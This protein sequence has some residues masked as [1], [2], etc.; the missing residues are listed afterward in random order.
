MLTRL[1]FTSGHPPPPPTPSIVG[2][3]SQ[4]TEL[5]GWAVALCRRMSMIGKRYAFLTIYISAHLLA[6]T[7][8]AVYCLSNTAADGK[9]LA[10]QVFHAVSRA[11]GAVLYLD[12]AFVLFPTCH[13]LMCLLRQTFLARLL[14]LDSRFHMHELIAWSMV[15]FTWVHVSAQW[16]LLAWQ[17]ASREAGFKGFL[18]DSFA[19]GVGWTGHVMLILLMLISLTSLENARQTSFLRF[20]TTHQLCFLFIVL[21]CVHEDFVHQGSR[22]SRWIIEGTLWQYCSCEA[23]VYLGEVI[24]RQF[25][26]SAIV[27]MSKI[28]QHPS[29]VVEVQIEKGRLTP[30]IGQYIKI[31]F[32]EASVIQFHSFSLTS[33]PEEDYISVHV[34]CLDKS[35]RA[36][37]AS[38]GL[39]LS[40]MGSNRES[41][42]AVALGSKSLAVEAAPVPQ[43]RLPPVFIQ[44]PFGSAFN[45]VFRFE[46]VV[47]VG[48]G[49]GV[50]PFASVLKSIWYHVNHP[51]QAI[52]LRKV[53]FFWICRN[54]DTFEWFKSLILAIEA[55]D[56]DV[57]IEIHT[58]L[59]V[60]K[61]PED[62]DDAKWHSTGLQQG[63][64]AGRPDWDGIFESLRYIHRA[65]DIGVFHR[66]P[67]NLTEELYSKCDMSLTNTLV[68][69]VAQ[70]VIFK[71]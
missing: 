13:K 71:G 47:L 37:G 43:G 4:A 5:W 57:H 50:T 67:R 54:F 9:V 53:Y 20:W 21:W 63:T 58:Y 39:R 70:V 64:T 45:D 33:A 41:S 40:D 32:P 19:T 31:C 61:V 3:R 34:P 6:F 22:T 49:R 46:T 18:M 8:S 48:A 14:D 29:Q 42:G 35:S 26:R 66:G 16:T 51:R 1:R 15:L 23:V 7:L 28:I 10:T 52:Q 17:A 44:G 27:S 65:T 69:G 25:H 36:I 62:T 59:T 56:L 38:L 2:M 55:Q 30:K 11:S 68:S 24:L 12:V 60:Q